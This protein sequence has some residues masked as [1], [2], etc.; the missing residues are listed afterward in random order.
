MTR[1]L[2]LGG[3][4]NAEMARMHVWCLVY[5]DKLWVD[6]FRESR[7]LCGIGGRLCRNLNI[8]QRPRPW[9]CGGIRRCHEGRHVVPSR[10]VIPGSQKDAIV[11]VQ[12]TRVR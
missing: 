4:G 1:R 9:P 6:R 10:R 2:F 11:G 3:D 8:A 7:Q 12:P 5:A